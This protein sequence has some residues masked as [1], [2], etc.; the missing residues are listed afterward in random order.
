MLWVNAMSRRKC[1]RPITL[2]GFFPAGKLSHFCCGFLLVLALCAATPAWSQPPP[3]FPGHRHPQ[4][5]LPAAAPWAT[6]VVAADAP[7]NVAY[8]FVTIPAPGTLAQANSINDDGVLTGIYS[9]PTTH[10][11][12]FI[13]KDGVFRTVDYPGH[14]YTYLW[15]LNNNGQAIGYYGDGTIAHTV[16]YSV[17]SGTWTP[18]PDIP[19][20]S[21]NLGYGLNDAGLVIGN[22]YDDT[23]TI[24]V[25]W[26]WDPTTRSYSF[27]TVPGSAQYST[28]PNEINDKGQIGGWYQDSG[29]TYHGFIKEYGTYTTVD[30]PGASNTLPDGISNTGVLQGQVLTAA[31]AYAAEGFI[32]TPGGVFETVNYP[33]QTMTTLVGINGRGDVCGFYQE[34]AN[35]NVWIAFVAYRT[36]PISAVP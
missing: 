8:R 11:Q 9:N 21:Y 15:Q 2:A 13:W 26:I 23:Y 14:A 6:N 27:F 4:F 34:D 30:F 16:I 7:A 25:A 17:E 35:P 22:T 1:T 19:G 28:I 32:A 33:G 3:G 24:N 18:L 31:P 29:G 12:S 36:G 20:Y 5:H 10:T